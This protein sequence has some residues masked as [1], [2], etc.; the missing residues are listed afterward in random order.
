MLSLERPPCKGHFLVVSGTWL[1]YN[2]DTLIQN[3]AWL[4][5]VAH[6]VLFV[7]T[8]WFI[9]LSSWESGIGYMPGNGTLCEQPPVCTVWTLVHDRFLITHRPVCIAGLGEGGFCMMSHGREPH[10][11]PYFF[12]LCLFPLCS[13]YMPLLC[14]CNKSEL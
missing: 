12:C 9:L 13:G 1:A 6:W 14:P 3:F 5:S 8:I 7:Q 2:T 10:E 11:G 4:I